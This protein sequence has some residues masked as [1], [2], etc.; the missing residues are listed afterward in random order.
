[1]NA[2]TY[3]EVR[4]YPD[5]INSFHKITQPAVAK[6]TAE[7]PGLLAIG[8]SGTIYS[9]K[10]REAEGFLRLLWGY[11]PYYVQNPMDDTFDWL[12]EGITTGTDPEQVDYW[13]EIDDVNQL[14]V[15][16][17][18]LAIF[19]LLNKEK[20]WQKTTEEQR[21]KIYLWLDQINEYETAQNNWLFFRI[22]VDV[23]L[24]KNFGV[25]RSEQMEADFKKIE[26]FYVGDGWYFDGVV[27]QRDYY[28]SFAIHYYS[29]LYA[30]VYEEEDPQRSRLFKERAALFAKSFQTWFDKDGR[31]LPFGRS[32][33]YRFAQSAF[34][35]AM[36]YA[37]VEQFDLGIAKTLL[38]KNLTFWL[39][40]DIF[41]GEG[42]LKIGYC[43]EDLVMAEEYNSPGSPY[44]SLKAFLVLALPK[45]DAIWQ[46]PESK[47]APDGTTL[48]EE[49]R[50][51]ITRSEAGAH[52]QG[53][54]VAQ[55]NHLHSHCEAKYSKFVY[56]TLFGFN[57]SKGLVGLDKGAFDSI[58]AV[59]ER[60]QFYRVR[61]KPEHFEVTEDYTK[62]IWQ[63]WDNVRIT[64]W[65][66]PFGSWHVRLHLIDSQ[67]ELTISDGGFSVP[68]DGDASIQVTKEEIGCQIRSAIGTT[69][70]YSLLGKA[71]A[72]ISSR[73]ANVNV[74]Y[75]NVVFP[76]LSKELPKGR[77]CFCHAFLGS[78]EPCD[79]GIPEIEI[80]DSWVII[81]AANQEKRLAVKL[82]LKE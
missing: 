47:T 20:V 13:G 59:S 74:L 71:Q 17:A 82:D 73:Q 7:H 45:T 40:Q 26:S 77:T 28:V 14:M 63:P 60:D 36:L 39:S 43:Y 64:S 57:V 55:Y 29:L 53:Y 5:F 42:L 66:L 6:L 33:T 18:P 61:T 76:Y 15:E 25:D 81:K 30:V 34:W 62:T 44:W 41:S 52:V 80:T 78:K 67:R 32:L 1:M 54:P 24:K 11:A 3:P 70:V 79:T 27:Q 65:I 22:L 50:M 46:L 21:Q 31:A 2:I 38:G 10:I 19:L 35:S 69:G 23:C 12:I 16:M 8:S 58:L 72:A 68:Y 75:N 56:S 4:S 37:K 48:I 9:E 51:L 49:G